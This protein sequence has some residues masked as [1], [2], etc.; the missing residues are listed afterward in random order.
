[1]SK[2]AKEWLKMEHGAQKREVERCGADGKWMSCVENSR[3]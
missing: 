1:M 3:L 2:M